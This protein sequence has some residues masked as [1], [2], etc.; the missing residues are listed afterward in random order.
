MMNQMNVVATAV[1]GAIV[2]SFCYMYNIFPVWVALGVVG[3]SIYMAVAPGSKLQ[4]K[5][6]TNEPWYMK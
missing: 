5:P 4:K 6:P 3:L 1:L 2:W